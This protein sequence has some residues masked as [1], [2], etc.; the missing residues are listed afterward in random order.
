M[1]VIHTFICL[2]LI[3]TVHLPRLLSIVPTIVESGEKGG[4][5]PNRVGQTYSIASPTTSVSSL[6]LSVKGRRHVQ[7]RTTQLSSLLWVPGV[8]VSIRRFRSILSHSGP[9]LWL[10]KV[11]LSR[12]TR[13]VPSVSL[14]P[15]VSMFLKH[16]LC[17][18]PSSIQV[19]LSTPVP[20]R[21][22]T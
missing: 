4:V 22:E 13:F 6:G 17:F 3:P 19:L 20:L 5:C 10:W 2:L 16:V 15:K 14:P 21:V 1:S 9:F 18:R 12:C 11:R 7:E 8:T